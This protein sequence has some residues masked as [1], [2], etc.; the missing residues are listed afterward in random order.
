MSDKV[1]IYPKDPKPATVD[2]K[3]L[4][5]PI[6]V[7]VDNTVDANS[8]GSINVLIYDSKPVVVEIS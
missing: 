5:R 1:E 7:T 2:V 3:L 6:P 8:V 4:W